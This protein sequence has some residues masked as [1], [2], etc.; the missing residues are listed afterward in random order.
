MPVPFLSA[1]IRSLAGFASLLALV[2]A[3]VLPWPA[4]VPGRATGAVQ[5][6]AISTP[7][8]METCPHHPEGCPPDCSCPKLH[9]DPGEAEGG[10]LAG[11]ALARCTA[12]GTAVSPAAP[13]VF[14]P[15]CPIAFAIPERWQSLPASPRQATAK[16][17]RAPPAKI[18]IG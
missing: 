16:G 7:R 1:R 8:G 11:P 17:F 5:A 13:E 18:P 9:T 12:M 14:L 15:A 4:F 3:Q 10:T 6:A 2:V